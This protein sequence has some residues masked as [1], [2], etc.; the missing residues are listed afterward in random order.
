VKKNEEKEIKIVKK[1][2]NE[3]RIIKEKGKKNGRKH[4]FIYIYIYIMGVIVWQ[5]N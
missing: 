1:G 2:N 5:I 4:N 3:K